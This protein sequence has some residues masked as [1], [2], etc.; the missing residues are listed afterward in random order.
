MQII[1]INL[2]KAAAKVGL[3]IS[4]DKTKVMVFQQKVSGRTS[5]E[6]KA[7]GKTIE[8]VEKFKYLRSVISANGNV[9]DGINKKIGKT[10][11]SFKKMNK[12]WSSTTIY[13]RFKIKLYHSIILPCLLYTTELWKMTVKLEKK[14]NAFHQ[15]CL[16]RILKISYRD[17]VTNDKNEILR[18]TPMNVRYIL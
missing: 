13:T 2:K 16:P 18:K 17:H 6:I 9:D 1:T 3:K 10:T 14:L 12:I 4:Q 15:R 8:T 5:D 7:E 11:A